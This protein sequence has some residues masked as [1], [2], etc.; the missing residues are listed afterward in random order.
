MC[1][2][3]VKLLSLEIMTNMKGQILILQ[4]VL[5]E[6]TL[7]TIVYLAYFQYLC[8]DVVVVSACEIQK[9]SRRYISLVKLLIHSAAAK[10]MCCS[11]LSYSRLAVIRHASQSLSLPANAHVE[12][13]GLS[14]QWHFNLE[15]SHAFNMI[16]SF[17]WPFSHCHKQGFLHWLVSVYDWMICS[18]MSDF[19]CASCTLEWHESRA[20]HLWKNKV[21]E[22]IQFTE[23]NHWVTD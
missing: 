20:K 3:Q 23:Q 1:Q 2:F 11:S 14:L 7:L 22:P 13:Y 9:A 16:C 8:D 12:T 4:S 19:K 18:Y 17:T 6:L 10:M 15:R 21:H 5:P